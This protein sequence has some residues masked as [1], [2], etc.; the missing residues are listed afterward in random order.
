MYYKIIVVIIALAIIGLGCRFMFSSS[1]ILEEWGLKSIDATQILSRRL[2]AIYFGLAVLL[3]LSLTSLSKE[4]T[5]ILGISAISG[6]LAISG[7]LDLMAGRV[8]TDI[9][10]SI[11]AE[12]VLCLVLL[13]TFL[14]KR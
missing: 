6:F 3:F 5:I 8:N 4:Q 7:I 9:I 14:I 10:R 13:S 11:V 12:I 2:A 1:S